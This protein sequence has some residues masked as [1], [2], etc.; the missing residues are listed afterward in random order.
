MSWRWEYS[1]KIPYSES[2]EYYKNREDRYIRKNVQN[3]M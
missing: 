2:D 1:E 3:R